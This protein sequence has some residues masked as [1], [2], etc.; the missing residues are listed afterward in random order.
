MMTFLWRLAR[1]NR[2]TMAVAIVAAFATSGT[3]LA[4][5]SHFILGGLNTAA[6]TTTIRTAADAAVLSLQNT[7]AGGSSA[8][9]LSITVP[10]DR[11]PITVSA[12]A[13]KATNLDADSVDG[14][15]A[16]DFIQGPVE[17]WHEVGTPGEPAW[18]RVT[19]YSPG[20]PFVPVAFLKDPFGFVHLQGVVRAAIDQPD[21]CDT[22]ALFTLPTGYRPAGTV[23]EAAI[24]HDSAIF[25]NV[26]SQVDVLANRSVSICFPRLTEFSYVALDGITFQAAP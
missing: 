25:E 7:N 5:T 9:G 3:A 17:A 18:G 15:D 12:G 22:Y 2:A 6:T 24:A 13:G 4:A 19:L 10:A 8:S 23:T 26:V 20:D 14:H 21:G 11:P 16:G 1:R